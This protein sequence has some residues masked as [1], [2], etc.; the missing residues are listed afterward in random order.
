MTL[1]GVPSI[2]YG[3]EI[4]MEGF[5]DPYNRRPYKWNTGD[6]NLREAVRGYW[7]ALPADQKAA[8]LCR[9]VSTD[10]L[11]GSLAPDAPAFTE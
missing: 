10:E 6:T 11:Y 5:K 3:D 1:P 7:A 2:Y 4:G 9:H 8:F